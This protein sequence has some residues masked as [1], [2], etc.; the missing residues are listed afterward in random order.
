M[1]PTSPFAIQ[2][3]LAYDELQFLNNLPAYNTSTG[4]DEMLE[5]YRELQQSGNYYFQGLSFPNGDDTL[6]GGDQT[7]NGTLVVPV[8][9]YITGIT[10]YYLA[11]GDERGAAAI[12]FKMKIFDKGSKESI[13][14]YDYCIDGLVGRDMTQDVNPYGGV[15]PMGP[16][17]LMS[18]FIITNPGQLG[19]EVVNLSP[20]D[21]TIQ[22][23]LTCAVP[24]GL[25]T[26]GQKI[27]SRG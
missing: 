6:V 10:Q 20:N 18:P 23:L 11:V 1:S 27:V 4:A 17:L 15:K 13:F 22:V 5:L 2:S 12:G 9:T 25:Q 8:G 16:G 21:A 14:Y 19:W 3:P 7:L 24:V 26:I